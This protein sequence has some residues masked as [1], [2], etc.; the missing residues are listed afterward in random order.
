M[1]GFLVFGAFM[2]TTNN[3]R[4]LAV[5]AVFSFSST[6]ADTLYLKDGQEIKD[7][8]ITEISD[9]EVKYKIGER[10][11]V[12]TVKKSNIVVIIYDDG[13]RET[14]GIGNSMNNTVQN[15]SKETEARTRHGIR[16][17]YNVSTTND[18]YTAYGN[19]FEAG[20]Q[21]S[22]LISG[23]ITFNTGM[24]FIYRSPIDRSV[25]LSIGNQYDANMYLIP[26]KVS[27]KLTEFAISVPI[28][29]QG[30]PFGGP[31]F[32]I[33]GGIQ[34]DFPLNSKVEKYSY[35]NAS[36]VT[37]I[38]IEYIDVGVDRAFVD[39]GVVLGTGWFVGKHFAIDWKLAVVGLTAISSGVSD[40][41]LQTALGVSYWL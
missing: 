23:S 6:F 15:E 12:Y 3:F 18:T 17:A 10:Q 2:R 41:L 25:N 16:A 21:T 14:F 26:N 5:L 4:L 24:N 35:E 19:G 7:A 22:L 13:T 9:S 8:V 20:W 34:M 36:N 27:V 1:S 29:I 31:A 30:M 28:L 32:Y 37:S 40:R 33:N 38:E 39:V 11:V